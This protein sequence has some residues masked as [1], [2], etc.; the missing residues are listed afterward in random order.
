MHPEVI[1]RGQRFVQLD[2]LVEQLRDRG[3]AWFATLADV[4]AHV[5]PLL[6]VR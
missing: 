1:G 6:E 2:R 5:R 3:G 4:A